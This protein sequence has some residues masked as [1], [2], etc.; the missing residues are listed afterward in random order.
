MSKTPAIDASPVPNN[1]LLVGVQAVA[2]ARQCGRDA[3]GGVDARALGA[4]ARLQSGAGSGA[5]WRVDVGAEDAE[6]EGFA[7]AAEE[8]GGREGANR[9]VGVH[10]TAAT[11]LGGG[12]EGED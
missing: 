2:L 10:G 1:A 9:G 12:S 5:G 3:S 11:A 6:G 8:G 4:D 7:A